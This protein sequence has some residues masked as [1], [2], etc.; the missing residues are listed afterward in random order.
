MNN[1][2]TT[3]TRVIL[4]DDDQ[5]ELD[6]YSFLLLSMGVKHI[7]TVIDSRTLTQVLEKYH[8]SVLFLDL[9]MPH[10]SGKEVL[11][12]VREQFPHT[13]VI[14]CTANSDI[15]MAVEC[16]KL[17]AHDYLVKPINVN[18]FG[19]ALRN[20]L[21]ICNL[22]NEVMTLKGLSFGRN[23]NTPHHF[24][25]IITKN[26]VMAG[27]FH[28]IESIASSGQPVLILGETGSG[29][30]LFA[31]AIHDVSG[32]SGQFVAI[33]V[34]GLDDTLF[35]DTLFGHKKGAYTGAD[36]NRSGL[37][38]TAG[39]G[40]IFLDEIGDLNPSSQVKLLRLLQEGIY[41]PLGDDQ[42]QN[43]RA[44]IIT[45]TNKKLNTLSGRGNEFRVD[46]YYRLSTHLIQIP[47]L[48]ERKEDLPL[49]ADHLTRKAANSMGK[50]ISTIR[51][52]LLDLL[53]ELSFPGNIRELKTYIYDAVAQC[54]TDELSEH[55]ILD[56]LNP[57]QT[58]P[59][60]G[61][62]APGA[63]KLDVLA[64][65]TI[66]GHF[67]TLSELTRYAIEQSLK[68]AGNNQSKAAKALGISKQALSKRLKKRTP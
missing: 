11:V 7:T 59:D 67:P 66:F 44:R 32:A 17:G 24:S 18:T 30:E 5:S 29:K 15:E 2:S 22:R 62:P 33:D 1:F 50:K 61:T 27:L 16:L 55:A 12:D 48:R 41:Y 60:P 23:L 6:A 68:K 45:A 8:S 26:P 38:E 31:K 37:I 14:I 47:P 63:L 3:D 10:K 51:Q 54:H 56:R 19:S 28:Y 9:N 39:Q 57:E 42:P 52:S 4:V 49:L 21:E 35:S 34:S 46:L 20:A 64:L 36:K 58:G 25:S 65:E 40:T 43:C 53:S 13:P